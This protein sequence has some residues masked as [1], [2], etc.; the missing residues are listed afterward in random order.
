M[1]KISRKFYAT[2]SL[3]NHVL[4]DPPSRKGPA[5]GAQIDDQYNVLQLSAGNLVIQGNAKIIHKQFAD[6]ATTTLEWARPLPDQIQHH[7]DLTMAVKYE[8]SL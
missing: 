4:W 1:L 8:I 7:L 6:V 5:T 3:G 2:L